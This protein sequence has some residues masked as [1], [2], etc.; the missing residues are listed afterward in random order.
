MAPVAPEAPA[1]LTDDGLPNDDSETEDPSG[2]DDVFLATDVEAAEKRP[3]KRSRAP[4]CGPLPADSNGEDRA[5][6]DAAAPVPPPT[7]SGDMQLDF[8]KVIALGRDKREINQL[9]KICERLAGGVRPVFYCNLCPVMCCVLY[10]A[11]S[12]C[13]P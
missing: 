4:P 2:G 1:T 5:A 7:A 10:L 3:A 11:D 9:T 6:P 13:T 8:S 12:C